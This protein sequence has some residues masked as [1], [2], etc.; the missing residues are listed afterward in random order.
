MFEKQMGVFS[1][2]SIRLQYS[3]VCFVCTVICRQKQIPPIDIGILHCFYDEPAR[4][5][6][7]LEKQRTLI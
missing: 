2:I 4:C 5:G 7:L 1:M 6:F 3:K